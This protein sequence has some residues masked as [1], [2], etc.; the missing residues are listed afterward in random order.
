MLNDHWRKHWQPQGFRSFPSGPTTPFVRI[1]L[2]YGLRSRVCTQKGVGCAFSPNARRTKQWRGPALPRST[3]APEQRAYT[4]TMPRMS[5]ISGFAASSQRATY[6]S[7]ASGRW[8]YLGVK[9]EPIEGSHRHSSVLAN[10]LFEGLCHLYAC[11]Q[12][13]EFTQEFTPRRA[14]GSWRPLESPQAERRPPGAT[15]VAQATE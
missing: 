5:K 8:G 1:A 2:P 15:C 14:S 10:R 3:C 11:L 6:E 9:L 13:Q 4:E 7:V 12:A